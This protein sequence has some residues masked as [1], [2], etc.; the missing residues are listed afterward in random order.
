MRRLWKL[1]HKERG[2]SLAVIAVG[3]V[4][5]LGMVGLVADVGNAYALQRKVRNA[6]DA[7]ALA[8]ARELA[9]GSATTN[10]QVLQAVRRYAALNYLPPESVQAWYSDID[11]NP[12]QP[13]NNDGFS[14][15]TEVNGVDVAG[16]V[17][18]C[19]ASTSTYFAHLVGIHSF[20]AS[21]QTSG[22]VLC[23]ACSAGAT[24]GL[25]PAAIDADAFAMTEGMPVINQEYYFW[26]NPTAAGNFGWLSWNDDAGHT[27]NSVLVTNLSD[28]KRSGVWSVGDL[29]PTG[30]GVMPSS[31]VEAALNTLR[32]SDL[33]LNSGLTVP[34]YDRTEGSGEN[35]RYHL[36]GFIQLSLTGYDLQSDDKYLKGRVVRWVEPA[37]EGGCV[38]LGVCTVKLRP[39]LTEVRS[40]TGVVS[41]WEPLLGERVATAET[42]IP[43]DVVN[44]LDISG[45]MADRWGP[46]QEVKLETAK[47]VLIDFNNQLRPDEGDR[48]ALVT[49]PKKTSVS[50]YSLL[51]SSS[52]HNYKYLGQVRSSLT[53]NIA[54]INSI[55]QSLS[56][57]GGT[58]IAGAMQLARGE[59]LPG[60]APIEGRVPVLIIA[61]DG[62]AN[63]KVDGR[64]TGF[65]GDVYDSPP[66]NALAVQ[67]AQ[68]QANMAKQAGIIVFTIAIGDDFNSDLLQAMATEDSDPAKPHFFQ[69]V[70]QDDLEEIY[71][72]IAYRVTHIG[73]EC[74][75]DEFESTGGGATVTIYRN[76]S[77]TPYA[78]TTASS[79]GSYV[80]ADVE[81]GEYTFSVYLAKNGLEFDI[82]TD[83]IGGPAAE[84]PITISVGEGNGTYVRDLYLRTSTPL[85]CQ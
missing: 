66:C 14:P 57:T 18:Q 73:S 69:A 50:R 84:E 25:F 60:G 79:T 16:V 74:S 21:E 63:I 31:S 70:T 51:C 6:T 71:N 52:T 4:V 55:I 81:P 38:D 26:G 7:A 75:V 41:T 54:S 37:G 78:Q 43:V 45:S 22:L 77:T 80:F 17:V 68:E 9:R 46:G 40:I 24:Y 27:S 62:I 67:H 10:A 61:S 29:V 19:Q 12:L 3:I 20:S 34:V 64:W 36:I 58:P 49:F 72:T 83:M 33:N 23:G 35:A 76:G 65:P 28:L 48:L 11:G 13:V 1:V 47:R 32:N 39:P 5:L 2:Q 30:P 44:V 56:A 8:G 53:D 82:L 15:P 85:Q 59:A 42:H